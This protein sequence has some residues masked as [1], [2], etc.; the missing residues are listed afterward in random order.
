[1]ILQV[2]SFE[3]LKKN[4]VFQKPALLFRFGYCFVCAQLTDILCSLL[5]KD[6]RIE[7]SK[8]KASDG[9]EGMG[10]VCAAIDFF[11]DIKSAGSHFL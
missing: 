2:I 5:I 3:S 8:R 9:R 11:L 1:M 4:G 7:A 10:R 6:I